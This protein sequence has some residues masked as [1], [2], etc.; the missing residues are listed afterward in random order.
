MTMSPMDF[1]FDLVCSDCGLNVGTFVRFD[2]FGEVP[3]VCPACLS[4]QLRERDPASE[5]G[6]FLGIEETPSLHP[7]S[8]HP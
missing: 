8:H 3:H 6:V 4:R 1:E 7:P 2:D 5:I